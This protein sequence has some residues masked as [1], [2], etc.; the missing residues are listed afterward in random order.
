MFKAIQSQLDY[1]HG[2][3]DGQDMG[4]CVEY[5]VYFNAPTWSTGRWYNVVGVTANG[6]LV[7]LLSLGYEYQYPWLVEG[8]YKAE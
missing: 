2:N 1:H 4:Y 7:D 5:H 6:G 8:T 3:A